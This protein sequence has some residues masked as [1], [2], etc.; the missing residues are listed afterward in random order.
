MQVCW[1]M[2]E[3][4]SAG[5]RPSRIKFDDPWFKGLVHPNMKIILCFTHPWGILGVYDFLLSDESNRSYIKKCPGSSKL[6]HCS[7]WV[8]FFNS[9]QDVKLSTRIH[10]KTCLNKGAWIKA[11]C[12]N[13]MC[14]CKKYI[15]ISNVINTSLSLHLT[16]VRGSHSGG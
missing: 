13:S 14:F 12:S 1:G 5:H 10:N 11:S 2:L 7:G 6:Y 9:P 4:N 15:H 8:V 16:V 3:L